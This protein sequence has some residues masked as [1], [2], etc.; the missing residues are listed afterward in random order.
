[1]MNWWDSRIYIYVYVGVMYLLMRDGCLGRD[2]RDLASGSELKT[3]SMLGRQKA[4]AKEEVGSEIKWSFGKYLEF[5]MVGINP[6]Y[7]YRLVLG[8]STML[9]LRV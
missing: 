7:L 8:W 2:C 1:M 5:D 3:E 4:K 6:L 9:L